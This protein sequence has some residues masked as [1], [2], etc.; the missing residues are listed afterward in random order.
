M[1]TYIS[2]YDYM[3]EGS[4]LDPIDNQV[5]PDPLSINYNNLSLSEPPIRYEVTEIFIQKPYLFTN[6]LYGISSMDDIIL[7]LNNIPHISELD[8][9]I[10]NDDNLTKVIAFPSSLIEI[11]SFLSNR[12]LIS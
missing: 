2:R 5:Y 9:Q 11:Q 12:E 6:R 3:M 4:V 7:T 8:K 10:S 1:G